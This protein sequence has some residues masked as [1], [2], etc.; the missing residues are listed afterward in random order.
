MLRILLTS[1]ISFSIAAEEPSKASTPQKATTDA[2][3]SQDQDSSEGAS[4]SS[5]PTEE[6]DPGK[7]YDFSLATDAKYNDLVKDLEKFEVNMH[8]Q[9]ESE[10]QEGNAGLIPRIEIIV[11][12]SGSMGQM[13]SMDKSRMYY[14]KKILTRYFTDQ[15]QTKT[16]TGLRLYGS[17]RKGD[18]TDNEL[19]VPFGEKS[20]PKIEQTVATLTPTGKTPL[21]KA[22]QAAALD[23]KSYEGPKAMVV[24]TDGED[25]CGGGPCKEGLMAKNDPVL[26]TQIFLVAIGFKPNSD[27]LKK[28][29]C[30]GET[31]TAN[32]EG[33]LFSAL[34][35]I[36]KK[37]FKKFINLI[38]KSPDPTAPVEVFHR[39]DGKWTF[40]SVFT[41]SFGTILPPG[42]YQA[43]VKL[44]PP[45]RFNTFKI[46]PKKRVT[47][48]VTGPGKLNVDFVE[49]VLD[50]DI[51]DK[52]MKLV[53]SFKSDKFEEVPNGR[54]NIKI[55][56][57]PFFE[58][59]ITK[60][61]VAPGGEYTYKLLGVGA[62]KVVSADI[63]GFYVYN[64]KKNLLGNFLTNFPF[65]LP[66]GSYK[67]HVTNNCSFE[68]VDVKANGKVLTLECKQ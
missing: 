56:K 66:V 39:I 16:E 15:Y 68:N 24:F 58:K 46:P 67:I 38:V 44:N 3:A 47:L 48:T 12:S 17:R 55:H 51:L 4:K 53:K 54:W 50:V 32:S 28:I 41:A 14:M 36:N 21:F 57:Q 60:Y 1:I 37:I 20:L 9:I 45:Y 22:V 7:A 34:G 31:S 8:G 23:L 27:D 61:D 2:E 10:K 13:L 65:A 6:R 40:H 64:S 25:T 11:D 35:D 18:C 30:L 59:M 26:N 43:L 42:E 19:M 63:I 33:E 62:V 29:S 5:T 52:D 49:G